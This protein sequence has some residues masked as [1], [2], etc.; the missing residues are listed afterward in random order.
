[1]SPRDNQFSL[2]IVFIALIDFCSVFSTCYN[3]YD[4]YIEDK[5]V[6]DITLS[7][8]SEPYSAMILQVSA[9]DLI[10]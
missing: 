6:S 8:F 9:C 1:M 5:M 2:N 10:C 7:W 3:I 4:L